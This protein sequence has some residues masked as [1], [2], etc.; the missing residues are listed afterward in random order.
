MNK[1]MGRPKL[2]IVR[3]KQIGIRYSDDEYKI[4]QKKAIESNK[5]IAQYIRDKSLTKWLSKNQK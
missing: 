5:T 3:K 2:E 1:K 4:I